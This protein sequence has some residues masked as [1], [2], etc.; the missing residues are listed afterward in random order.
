MSIR[1]E[2]MTIQK[3]IKSGKPFRR[4]AWGKQFP[5]DWYVKI[6]SKRNYRTRF[7]IGDVLG[8]VTNDSFASTINDILATDWEVKP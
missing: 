7:W 8:G 5:K 1:G 6:R 3:A 2:A 4:K